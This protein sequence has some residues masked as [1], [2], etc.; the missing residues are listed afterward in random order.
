MI[1]FLNPLKWAAFRFRARAREAF[2]DYLADIL[3]ATQGR[4]TLKAILAHDAERYGLNTPRGRLSDHWAYQIEEHGD[5]AKAFAGTL[6]AKEVAVIGM[7]QRI[8]GN[9]LVSGM[10]DLS[11]LVRLQIKINGILLSTMAMG[12][13]GLIVSLATMFAVAHFTVPT[14]V[15][16]FN[17]VD[18]LM[19]GPATRRL[20][21]F[22]AWLETWLI[23][24]LIIVAAATVVMKWVLPRWTGRVRNW[25]DRHLPGLNLYRDTQAISFLVSLAAILQ[26]RSGLNH[27]MT[28][29]LLLMHEH[30]S[31]WLRAHIAQMSLRLSDAQAG[32]SVFKTG[33][34]D[35]QSYWY[36]E[37]VVDALG[38]DAAL[39]KTRYRLENSTTA[40]VARRA[41]VLRWSMIGM[42]L[43][44]LLGTML[45]HYAVI[46]EMRAALLLTY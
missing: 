43:A 45:W 28:E 22:A 20:F 29:A 1:H 15:S 16:S 14:L 34:L 37:D 33:L 38:M 12:Y 18:P 30:S 25:A 4:K 21:G 24:I 13:F 41:M 7:L 2:Y 36:L 42:A 23:P 5:V 32:A 10:R 40:S 44:F 9:A 19:Y 17:Q 8:G 31:P 6:P 26:P 27:S 39:Q 3:D 35:K 46:Y 11:G